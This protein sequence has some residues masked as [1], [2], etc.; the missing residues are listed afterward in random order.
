MRRGWGHSGGPVWGTGDQEM[1]LLLPAA[2]WG[3]EAEGCWALLRPDRN[4]AKLPEEGQSGHWEI[5]LCHE[6]G[7]GQTVDTCT[8]KCSGGNGKC[9]QSCAETSG[10]PRGGQDVELDDLWRFFP[11]EQ[12]NSIQILL[13][14]CA[15]STESCFHK[16]TFA[17]KW[18]LSFYFN[19]WKLLVL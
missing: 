8:Y 11:S 3:R 16:V 7:T 18:N 2:P 1:T 14:Q 5:V 6:G 19:S 13:R 17:F 12:F 9:S 4:S 10:E 15:D